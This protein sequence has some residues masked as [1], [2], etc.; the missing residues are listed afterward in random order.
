METIAGGTVITFEIPRIL[1][2][3]CSGDDTMVK[4]S[5]LEDTPGFSSPVVYIYTQEVDVGPNSGTVTAATH[6]VPT[7]TL[8]NPVINKVTDLTLASYSLPVADITE[9]ILEVDQTA[10]PDI[11]RGHSIACGGHICSKFNQLM[12][13]L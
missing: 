10:F 11:G 1:R 7:V 5:I 6:E 4:L 2:T 12:S 3:C 9:I 13:Y 8:S